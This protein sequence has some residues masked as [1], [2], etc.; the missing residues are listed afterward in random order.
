MGRY[1]E[2]K[3]A[4]VHE[5]QLNQFKENTVDSLINQ[6]GLLGKSNQILSDAEVQDFTNQMENNSN[7]S[8]TQAPDTQAPAQTSDS[9]CVAFL[10]NHVQLPGCSY[11]VLNE[12]AHNAGVL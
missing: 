11:A 3:E 6:I 12:C 5:L 10:Q 9:C 7:S 2:A 8:D 4:I 1:E